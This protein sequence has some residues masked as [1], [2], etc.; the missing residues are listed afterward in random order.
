MREQ[1]QVSMKDKV[2]LVTGA[3]G[4]IGK[5]IARGL[6]RT[7]ATVVIGA[8]DAARGDAAR[9]EIARDTGNPGVHVMV[10]DVAE[11]ASVR[12]FA[13]A[14]EARHDRLHVLVNN[15][16]AWFTDRRTNSAGRELTF[17]TNVLGPYALTALL[18]GRLRAGA[19]ARVVNVVSSFASDYDVDDLDFARRAF[20][21]FKAYGQSKA[22]LRLQTW[23]F[24]KA[25]EAAGVTVNAAAPGFVRTGFNRNAKGFMATMI[26]LSARL[27]A[28]SPAKG[29]ATPLWAATAPALAQVTGKYFDGLR[30]KDGGFHDAAMIQALDER[31]RA[32]L[33]P[34]ISTAAA[35]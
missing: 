29:A 18:A 21:G 22:A 6:A 12:A 15:A 20:D 34:V 33:G 23:S 4:G 19:P 16:G 31:C 25:L 2:A 14:F 26:N 35:A 27:F 13:R 7:G 3:S 8:R 9:E 5:E 10:V 1:E 24:A 28:V 32:L 17:A 11:P 30:E